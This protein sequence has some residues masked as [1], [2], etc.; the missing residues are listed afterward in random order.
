VN[1]GEAALAEK[2]LSDPW[3]RLHNLYNIIDKH[4]RKVRFELNWAQQQLYQ[5]MWY[6]N[7][8]LKARQLGISTFVCLLFLDR[9]LFNSNLAAGVIAHTRE[10]AEH[11]F[12]RIKF[13]YDNLPDGIKALRP[14]TIDSARELVF[15]NG[16]SL[17][18]GTS[19]R[20][21]TLQYLH[22]SEFGKICAKFP[23][24]AQEIITGSLNTIAPGQYIFIESTAEGR[25]GH[26]YELCKQAQSIAASGKD[27]TKL[28]FFFHFFPW[29]KESGYCIGSPV[30][31]PQE[32]YEYF[33]SLAGLGIQLD[34]EQKFWYAARHATQGEDMKREFP[35]T[36]EEAWEQST[37]GAYYAKQLINARNEK[38][39]GR[40]PYDDTVPV[41]TAWDLG[42]NDSTAVWFFQVIGKEIHLIEY[43][44]GS[45]ES[46]SHW[47]G[48]V[49]S[50]EYFYNKH[51][52]P[53][54]ILAHEYTSGMTRQVSARKMGVSLIAVQRVDL[55]PGIDAARNIL[56]RC[57]F[58]SVK[59]EKGIRALENYKK[60]WNDRQ[61]C[62]ASQPLHNW[63]SHGADAFR[64]LATGLCYI[65]GQ[66]SQAEEE[67]AKLE[68]LKDSSGLLPGNYL[69]M[70]DT[71]NRN[72]IRH[73]GRVF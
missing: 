71:T 5:D 29:W 28:D 11:L 53:H 46:L 21:S 13:A 17:R 56:N 26:F 67:R 8:I 64:T 15:S 54:D 16:S 1:Q 37:E 38:R 24:K 14:A 41:H 4:G 12:K 9:C 73:Q 69:Y 2:R 18:V 44:E 61:G 66:K 57:W 36:P 27:L 43:I 70:P 55:I 40:I 52:A 47:L 68:R 72:H 63:A 34:P 7:I 39:I 49:Q 6:C 25:E 59:C 19:M 50:K 60:E 32:M 51:L 23:D 22:I 10:D 3:W 58:D 31:M 45:G 65:T 35:S 62:W 20:G 33:A 42:Y 30:V 48:V